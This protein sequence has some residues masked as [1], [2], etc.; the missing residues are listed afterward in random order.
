M[1]LRSG[2]F[3]NSSS[4]SHK[5]GDD[6]FWDLVDRFVSFLKEE[7]SSRY[8]R[9]VVFDRIKQVDDEVPAEAVLHSHWKPRLLL[10]GET[11]TK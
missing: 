4:S 10:Q 3:S 9:M 6:H 11:G 5:Q 8:G 2:S 7:S 1:C